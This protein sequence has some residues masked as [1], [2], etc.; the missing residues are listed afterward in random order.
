[1]GMNRQFSVWQGKGESYRELT[2]PISR[3]FKWGFRD[4]E[5]QLPGIIAVFSSGAGSISRF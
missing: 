5:L 2:R 3:I 4:D 1:M